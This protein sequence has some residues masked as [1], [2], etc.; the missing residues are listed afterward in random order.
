MNAIIETVNASANWMISY[1]GEL[2]S[3]KAN[4]EKFGVPTSLVR[5]EQL[6]NL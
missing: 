4:F 6:A 2:S 1:Y 3:V 5:F